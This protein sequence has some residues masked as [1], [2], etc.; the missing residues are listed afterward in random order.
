MQGIYDWRIPTIPSTYV[1]TIDCRNVSPYPC[2]VPTIHHDVVPQYCQ[3]LKHYALRLDEWQR[4]YGS[5]LQK[6]SWKGGGLPHSDRGSD[7]LDHRLVPPWWFHSY[8]GNT[9][10]GKD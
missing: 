10:F 8:D 6:G 7:G 9:Y 2:L 4:D 3:R 1:G 5:P